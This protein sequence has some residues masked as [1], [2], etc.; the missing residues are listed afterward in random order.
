MTV[1]VYHI[2]TR[3]ELPANDLGIIVVP[4]IEADRCPEVV[5]TVFHPT[6]RDTVTSNQ[7]HTAFHQTLCAKDNQIVLLPIVMYTMYIYSC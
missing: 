1:T 7:L 5:S 4:A 6:L 2:L 3:S